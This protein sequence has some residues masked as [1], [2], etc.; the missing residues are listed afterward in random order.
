MIHVELASSSSS[1]CVPLVRAHEETNVLF[2][3]APRRANLERHADDEGTDNGRSNGAPRRLL[4]NDDG[5]VRQLAKRDPV[6]FMADIDWQEKRIERSHGAVQTLEH[7]MMRRVNAFSFE[8]NPVRKLLVCSVPSRT[9]H[10]SVHQENS[11]ILYNETFI[12]R[13]PSSS[14]CLSLLG[15]SILQQ[16]RSSLNNRREIPLK[17][18]YLFVKT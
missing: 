9:I 18:S 4:R 3:D 10:A 12:L 11:S 5:R 14:C 6:R 13:Y 1:S 15:D 16:Q 7:A 17:F 8:H 2:A